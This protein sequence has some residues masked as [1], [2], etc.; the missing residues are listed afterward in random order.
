MSV[1]LSRIALITIRRTSAANFHRNSLP[2]L[3]APQNQ[4]YSINNHLFDTARY[5]TVRKYSSA[6]VTSPAALDNANIPLKKKIL[7]K[8]PVI[9][10][11]TKKEG[12]YLTLAYATAN[13]YDL[14]SLKQALAQQK[15]Y[16][17]GT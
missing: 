3:F 15:L 10:D 1:F 8:K 7:H 9:E 11:L 12:H 4:F 17:P 13:A 16:E 2:E 6:T 5:F 14:K